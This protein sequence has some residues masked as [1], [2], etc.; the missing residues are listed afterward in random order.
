M[1]TDRK[2]LEALMHVSFGLID[3]KI[4][5]LISSGAMNNIFFEKG[6]VIQES[7]G[8]TALSYN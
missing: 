7:F 3:I 6:A 5:R 4:Q 2:K 8:N 1:I